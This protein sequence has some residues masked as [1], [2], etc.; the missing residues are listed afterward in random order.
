[1]FSTTVITVIS[2]ILAATVHPAFSFF[3]LKKS[4][5]ELAVNLGRYEMSHTGNR[6]WTVLIGIS[7]AFWNVRYALCKRPYAPV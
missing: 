5:R 4:H 3:F 6:Y 2:V 7:L 1:M